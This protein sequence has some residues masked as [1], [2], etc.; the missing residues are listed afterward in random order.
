MAES[1]FTLV[2]I[3]DTHLLADPRGRRHGWRVAAALDAVLTAARER[4]PAPDAVLLTGDLVED[5]SAAGYRRLARRLRGWA[6]LCAIPGNHDDPAAL[7]RELRPAWTGGVAAF[8]GWRLHLLDSRVPGRIGGR[9]GRRQLARLAR[10]LAGEP[11]LIAVH[12]PPVAVG[13]AWIDALGLDDGEALRAL[14]RER[15]AVRGV[16]SG[17]VHQ[18]VDRRVD[19]WR[20]LTTPATC[21]QFLPGSAEHAED[22]HRAP[23]YRVLRLHPDGRLA[24]RVFRVPAAR[25]IAGPARRPLKKIR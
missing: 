17:H 22:P 6:P 7:A 9:L 8:G 2:Q 13:T 20:L 4:F 19:G 11:A 25:E 14:L 3:T 21:R 15:P 5:E 10:E 18:S 16:V 1:T 23:G 12:H 24:S